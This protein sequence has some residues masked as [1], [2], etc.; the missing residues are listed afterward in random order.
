MKKIFFVTLFVVLLSVKS[1]AQFNLSFLTNSENS[2]LGVGYSFNEKL[3]TDLRVYSTTSF[4]DATIQALLKYNFVR[5]ED[6]SVYVS[7]GMILNRINA[8]VVPIGV[9][10]KPFKDYQKVSF[11]I[12]AQPY[13]ELD[14]SEAFISGFGGLRYSFN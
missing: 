4:S 3:S 8:V 10:F 2:L 13:Y 5:K 9:E 11:F 14:L 12:E 6:Y 1:N 7:A